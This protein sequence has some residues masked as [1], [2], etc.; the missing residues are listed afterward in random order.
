VH[1]A[2]ARI[3]KNAT[4]SA[5]ISGPSHDRHNYPSRYQ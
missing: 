3:P 5:L 2:A 4:S 1:A